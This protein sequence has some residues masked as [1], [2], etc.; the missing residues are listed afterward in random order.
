MSEP[1][2]K[3]ASRRR[4]PVRN[5]KVIGWREW[6]AL[7]G[8]GVEQVKVKVDTGAQTSALHAINL[9]KFKRNGESWVRFLIH[10]FQRKRHPEI[11]VE[12]PVVEYR[13][14]RSSN[15]KTSLRPVIVTP[16]TLHGE[17]W[18]IE[19]TLVSRDEMSFRMLLGREA[20]RGRFLVDAGS[21]FFSGYPKK[22]E[23]T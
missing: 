13:Q 3:K 20:I 5:K 17:T 8:L 22:K 18:P 4:R 21:G 14:V 16:V 12:A 11:S 2:K 9:K 1:A 7:P 10:P 23:K 15:G 6:V 19:L